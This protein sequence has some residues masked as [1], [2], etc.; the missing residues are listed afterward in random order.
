ME[1][2]QDALPKAKLAAEKAVVL[3]D[4][5]AEAHHSLAAVKLG[6][7]RDLPG[8]EK[9]F[10]RA[11]EL[12]PRAVIVYHYYLALTGQ[13]EEAIAEAKRVASIDP[14]NGA[15][16]AELVWALHYARKFDEAIEHTKTHH[17]SNPLLLA[18]NYEKKG[19][20]EQ[21]RAECQAAQKL[22]RSPEVLRRLGYVLAVT[23][24]RAEAQKIAEELTERWKKKYFPPFFMACLYAGLGDKDQAFAWLEKSY[25]MHDWKVLWVKIDPH[26]DSLRSD[27]RYADLLRRLNLPLNQ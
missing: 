18:V 1:F 26:C 5:L 25:Q 23:G 20:Y 7:D 14:F 3:D 8:A 13:T 6:F 21:A 22:G 2:P 15:A 27:P 17:Q 4:T 11:M 10:K 16:K 19:M 9:E 12:N 24:K